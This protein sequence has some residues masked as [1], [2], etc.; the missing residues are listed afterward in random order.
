MLK[1]RVAKLPNEDRFV[2]AS[3]GSGVDYRNLSV[4]ERQEYQKI[5]DDLN[6]KRI[7][8]H[9]ANK[10]GFEHKL[11]QCSVSGAFMFLYSN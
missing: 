6:R 5:A 3:R 2:Y 1:E 9:E 7:K 11:E 10:R 8:I 4:R